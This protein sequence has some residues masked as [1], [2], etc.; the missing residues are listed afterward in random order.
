MMAGF[1]ENCYE[2]WQFFI[3]PFIAGFVGWI[4]NVVALEMT[5]R[6]IDFFGIELF[7]IKDQPWG[8]FGWQGIIPA[9]AEKM[10]STCFDLMTTKLLNVQEQF[11]R[12][13]PKRFSEVM[14]SGLLLLIDEVLEEVGM[15]Y[16]PHVWMDLPQDVKDELVVVADLSS[17]KFLTAFMA[18]MVAHIEDVVDI[19][20]MTVSACVR[21]QRLMVKVFKVSPFRGILIEAH[22]NKLRFR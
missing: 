19:K 2:W 10:A 14:E 1:N 13:D 16:M 11:N 4:T 8:L 22:A 15:E 3:M 5:F 17:S 18:D 20:E 7:R 12:L 6:P 9:K 21:E